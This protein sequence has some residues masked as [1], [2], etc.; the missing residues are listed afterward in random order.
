MD[1]AVQR[2]TEK[3][4]AQNF[5]LVLN[6]SSILPFALTQ[7]VHK[8]HLLKNGPT[9][10]SDNPQPETFAAHSTW[11]RIPMYTE[12]IHGNITKHLENDGASSRSHLWRKVV[13]FLPL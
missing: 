12:G 10:A 8:A 4:I 9:S 3:K 6:K 7:T 2:S 13:G 11:L 5:L 1:P